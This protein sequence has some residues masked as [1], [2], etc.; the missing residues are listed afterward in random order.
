M[1]KTHYMNFLEF[2]HPVAIQV[3]QDDPKPE[4]KRLNREWLETLALIFFMT[5]ALTWLMLWWIND[6]A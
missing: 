6:I 5:F 3:I 1:T 4:P 2:S